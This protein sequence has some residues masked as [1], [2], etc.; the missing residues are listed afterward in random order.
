MTKFDL[1]RNFYFRNEL[2][3]N[4]SIPNDSVMPPKVST[5]LFKKNVVSRTIEDALTI[6]NDIYKK[7]FINTHTIFL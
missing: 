2:E 3:V 5:A 1:C 6:V 7:E 4:V